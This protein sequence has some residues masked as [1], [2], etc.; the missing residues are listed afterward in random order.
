L[1]ASSSTKDLTTTHWELRYPLI[2][3]SLPA[4]HGHRLYSAMSRI[5]PIIHEQTGWRMATIGGTPNGQ[6]EIILT[7]Y[8]RLRIRAK[9]EQ[10]P[11]FLKLVQKLLKV[12]KHSLVLEPPEIHPI[13]PSRTLKARLVVIK[14]FQEPEPFIGAVKY[15]LQKLGINNSKTC[16]PTN[17][18]GEPDRKVIKVHQ[19]KVVGFGVV[20]T[21]LNALDS[22]S[23]QINGCGGKP[24]MGCGFFSPVSRLEQQ[25]DDSDRELKE[26]AA[27]QDYKKKR[28]QIIVDL[29]H[30]LCRPRQVHEFLAYFAAKFTD[31]YQYITTEEYL[32]LAKLIQTEPEQIR[33]L[34]L[35]ALP[36]L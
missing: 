22:I 24:K 30:D 13:C 5:V 25:E 14:G 35:L 20:V 19:H 2:G 17:D 7:T 15:H 33:I 23:L 3:K 8:S 16:I 21:G 1:F 4:D 32:L 10:I 31:V 34:C 18:L 6:G 12:G 11:L 29:H 27:Y 26:I 36:V 28:Q 9:W